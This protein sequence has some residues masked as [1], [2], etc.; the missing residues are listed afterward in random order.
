MRPAPRMTC[1]PRGGGAPGEAEQPRRDDEQRARRVVQD[2]VGL[3]GDEAHRGPPAGPSRARRARPSG[4]A[5]AAGRA[6]SAEGVRGGRKAEVLSD[7]AP[8][9]LLF[10][11]SLSRRS[12]RTCTPFVTVLGELFQPMPPGSGPADDGS[13]TWRRVAG[14]EGRRSEQM[15]CLPFPGPAACHGNEGALTCRTS[16]PSPAGPCPPSARAGPLVGAPASGPLLPRAPRRRRPTGR[17]RRRRR[18]DPA[19]H[20]PRPARPAF[21][22]SP[23]P[24]ARLAP[25]AA[26]FLLGCHER[27]LPR[28]LSARPSPLT[29]AARPVTSH[30]ADACRAL[31]GVS[32]VPARPDQVSCLGR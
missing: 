5:T 18:P 1:D 30:H 32:G 4:P 8:R 19:R 12:H 2:G 16:W 15:S 21:R 29:V 22:R 24:A 3:R 20:P 7:D 31:E 9:G 14:S 28:G 13:R 27:G 25:R 10:F 11:R 6:R 17:S 26:A 23:C